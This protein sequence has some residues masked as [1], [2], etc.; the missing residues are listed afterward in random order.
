MALSFDWQRWKTPLLGLALFFVGFHLQLWLPKPFWILA[1]LVWS[2][3]LNIV[4]RK[5][6]RSMVTGVS[7][8]FL[9][10]VLLH[11]VGIGVFFPASTG[12]PLLW[13]LAATLG[14]AIAGPAL[15]QTVRKK[16]YGLCL[17]AFWVLLACVTLDSVRAGDSDGLLAFGVT[18]AALLWPTHVYMLWA[19]S[20]E[21]PRWFDRWYW[22]LP[23]DEV[24]PALEAQPY[25]VLEAPEQPV[26]HRRL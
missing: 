15:S 9:S 19:K 6:Q 22:R 12:W 26:V 14:V 5:L 10:G 21:W 13:M 4:Q 16:A 3:G 20:G 2:L 23:E 24:A 8:V 17:A 18:G 1:M 7:R 25:E 11:L